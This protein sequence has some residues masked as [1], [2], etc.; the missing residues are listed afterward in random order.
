MRDSCLRLACPYLCAGGLWTN[1]SSFEV[2]GASLYLPGDDM[3]SPE[4][5]RGVESAVTVAA[6]ALGT[7]VLWLYV[8]LVCA[9]SQ[10]YCYITGQISWKNPEGGDVAPSL[11]GL[12][13][14]PYQGT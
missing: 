6:P 9:G 2:P 3:H 14:A 7:S 10:G 4:D 12:G 8:A 5:C 13:G 1:S 11:K